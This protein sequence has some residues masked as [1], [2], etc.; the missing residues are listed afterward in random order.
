VTAVLLGILGPLAA[1]AGSWPLMVRTF[2]RN[3][4]QLTSVMMAAFAVKMAFFAAYVSLAIAVLKLGPVPFTASFTTAFIA[5]YA[6]EAV[7]LRRLLA[8]PST[9][10]RPGR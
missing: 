6:V 9:S 10:L 3:P 7:G 1:V 5:L 4:A 2:R 8:G